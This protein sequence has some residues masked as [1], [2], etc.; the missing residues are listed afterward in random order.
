MAQSTNG[1]Y[2]AGYW[3]SMKVEISSLTKLKAWE[4]YL[5]ENLLRLGSTQSQADT[6]LFISENGLL[7][8]Q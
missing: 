4:L 3:K 8:S 1:P 5:K 2:R 7:K 6:C